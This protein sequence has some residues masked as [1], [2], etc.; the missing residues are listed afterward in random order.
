MIKDVQIRPQIVKLLGQTL[1][2]IM[3]A[4]TLW[5]EHQISGNSGKNRQVILHSNKKIFCT[6]K[7]AMNKLKR[8]PME[9][10]KIFVSHIS[11]KSL[12]LKCIRNYYN[13]IAKN[14]Y[15]DLKTDKET[16]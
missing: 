7:E 10:E 8:Q 4:M 12:S 5:T 15:P 1:H 11:D 6:A 9:W 2:D 14:E 3:F 16:R 13:S